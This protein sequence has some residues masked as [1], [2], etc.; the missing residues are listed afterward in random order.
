MPKYGSQFVKQDDKQ[1]DK[2]FAANKLSNKLASKS[3]KPEA[4]ENAEAVEKVDVQKTPTVN[5]VKI[6]LRIS[7]NYKVVGKNSGQNYLF[8]GAGS[9]QDVEETDVEY[10]LSL[11]RNKSCCGGGGGNAIFELAGE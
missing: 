3:A 8:Q 10:L 5:T 1:D 6:R 7:S 2:G 9:T 4:V 11:R